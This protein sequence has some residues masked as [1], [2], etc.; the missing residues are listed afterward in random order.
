MREISARYY[1]DEG[2][3]MVRMIS[4]DDKGIQRKSDTV[5]VGNSDIRSLRWHLD[6]FGVNGRIN[7]VIFGDED[8]KKEREKAMRDY[9]ERYNEG[10]V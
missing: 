9:I 1:R 7:L 8:L 3:N 6:C 4:S 10:L 2:I 5:Q